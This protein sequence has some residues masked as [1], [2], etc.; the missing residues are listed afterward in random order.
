[1]AHWKNCKMDSFYYMS[2]ADTGH[3]C[4][5]RMDDKE[6]VVSYYSEDGYVQYKGDNDGSGHFSLTADAGDGKASLHNFK[7][8]PYLEGYWIESGQRGMWRITL[9]D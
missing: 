3:P 1:M 6:I 4:E 8:S 2:A 9:I 5:V 7:E